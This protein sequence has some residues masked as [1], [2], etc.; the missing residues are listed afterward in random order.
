MLV[1]VIAFVVVACALYTI[2]ILTPLLIEHFAHWK[3]TLNLADTDRSWRTTDGAGPGLAG[4]CSLCAA[5][6]VLFCYFQWQI[7]SIVRQL[8]PPPAHGDRGRD[9]Q[10]VS[11]V[12]D[13]TAA[14]IPSQ[15]QPSQQTAK[16]ALAPEA[17]KV[18]SKPLPT[19][20]PGC[21]PVHQFRETLIRWLDHIHPTWE[22]AFFLDLC[23][24]RAVEAL[25]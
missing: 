22:D 18:P 5:G 4:L 16:P 14:P 19:S 10:G 25:S 7:A 2:A 9:R 13:Q 20:P 8:R 17:S 23:I 6:G 12:S 15:P 21:M 11:Q 24:Q 3:T 1:V